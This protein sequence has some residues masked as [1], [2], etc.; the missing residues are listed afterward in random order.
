[1]NIAEQRLFNQHLM[2]TPLQNPAEVVGWLGAVQAQEYAHAKWAV[3]LRMTPTTE[4]AIEQACIQ[5]EILRTHVMRPTWHFVRAEDIRWILELTAP[6]VHAANAYMYRKVELDNATFAKSNATIG[7]ALVGGKQ[8][9]RVELGRVL[10]EVGIVADG[11]RLSY[12]MMSA[13]L[14]G[15]ICSGARRGKQFT[16]ALIDERAPHAKRLTREEALAE[17]TRRYF[18]SHGP[19]TIDDFA[20][21]SGLT[22]TEVK[23]GLALNKGLIIQEKVGEQALW[24]ALASPAP[25]SAPLSGHLLPVYDE[26][27]IAYKNHE[28]IITPPYAEQMKQIN[29]VVFT[30]TIVL[31]GQVVGMWKRTLEKKSVA[32]ETNLFGAWTGAEQQAFENAIR[33][34]S[35]YLELPV[36][37]N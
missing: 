14:D 27:T 33:R 13:E 23:E 18:T 4:A 28:A 6:R 30:S 3:S 1:M 22:K 35:D 24:L 29:L 26:Y 7:E 34:Y 19:A 11:V 2:G 31:G 32:L 10:A 16:Y 21:W 37:V 15:V 5:G 20:W 8:L 36:V 17:L 25:Q 9:T 12:L